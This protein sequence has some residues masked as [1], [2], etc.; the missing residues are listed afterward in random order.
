MFYSSFY[1][2]LSSPYQPSSVRPPN[3]LV[4]LDKEGEERRRLKIVELLR[5]LFGHVKV[6]LDDFFAGIYGIFCKFVGD[7]EC[8]SSVLRIFILGIF[9]AS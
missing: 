8:S 4:S 1:I 2:L 5:G 9:L 7:I 3:M 6:R